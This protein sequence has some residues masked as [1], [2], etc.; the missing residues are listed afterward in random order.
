MV[1][2]GGGNYAVDSSSVNVITACSQQFPNGGNNGYFC[3]P[4]LDALMARANGST[5]AA[6][7]TELYH[8]AAV[9]ENAQADLM[10]LYD[11]SGLWGVNNRVQGFQA[12][13]LAGL[14]LL[15]PGRLEPEQLSGTPRM[16]E[17]RW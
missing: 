13:G 7:R 17:A 2:F 1:L 8:Q 14:P 4:K 3:D 12:P 9:E 10:W 16:E 5:D 11:P 15:G 6:Q